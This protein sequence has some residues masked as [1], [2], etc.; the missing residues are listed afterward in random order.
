MYLDFIYVILDYFSTLTKKEKWFEWGIPIFL[1]VVGGIICV[2]FNLPIQ[3][4]II[5]EIITFLGVLLGFTLASLT[6]LLSNDK[7]RTSTQQYSTQRKI[8]GKAISL[9]RLIVVSFSYLIIMETLL[10]TLYYIGKLFSYFYIGQC[11]IIPNTIFIILAFNTLLSTIRTTTMLYF[12][13]VGK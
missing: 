6:L 2:S 12:I 8:R 7:V 11:S 13:V 10:C 5:K 4:D 1:S 3:Y 9:Y